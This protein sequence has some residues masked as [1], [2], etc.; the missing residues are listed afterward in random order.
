VSSIAERI[1]K[2]PGALTAPQL[3]QYLEMSPTTIYDMAAKGRIPHIRIG[4]SI[5]FDPVVTARWLR[6]QEVAVGDMS[7][8]KSSSVH[9]ERV[10]A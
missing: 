5:R 3:A 7:R 4:S 6:S 9:Q 2:A 10:A 8:R 1:E